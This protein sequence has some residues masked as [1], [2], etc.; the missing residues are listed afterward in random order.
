MTEATSSGRVV[1][2]GAGVGGL[3]SA[4]S[5]RRVGH[6][7]PITLVGAETHLP[8]DRPP[9]TKQVL[10]GE[11]DLPSLRDEYESL[12]LTTVLGRRAT[13]LDAASR[14]VTLDDGSQ[15]DYD[16]LVLAPGVE[17]RWL[18]GTARRPG[19]HAIRTIEDALGLRE[20]LAGVDSVVVV[21]GGFVGC[22]VAASARTLGKDVTIV[23]ALPAPLAAVVGPD[24]AAEI[25]AVHERNG[26][27][28]LAGT[29]VA[30]ILGDERV[31]GLKLS[32]GRILDAQEIVLGLGVVLDLDWLSGSGV[33]VD[34]G[35]VCSAAGR[36]SMPGV[37]AVGDAARWWHPLAGA[38][39]RVEHWTSASE[40]AEVVAANIVAGPDG[41]AT[42]LDEVPYFWSD[43]YAVKIQALGFLD[44]N[45]RT[46]VLRPND[47]F[48]VLYSHGGV[49]TGVLGL[50]AAR[51][52]MRM[53]PFIAG[54][55]SIEDAIA[56]LAG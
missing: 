9:L 10:R 53:R 18:R 54:R 37:Y 4:E 22:E 44:P 5:L 8:Y 48:V 41:A 2:V 24:A 43:Q 1:I 45:A 6:T 12:N 50:S 42:E 28:I 14:R 56:E 20:A 33:E 49:I 17:P 26:V 25:V 19:L 46:D 51:S 11:R 7:G 40:Q 32:D 34:D 47:R 23:E 16:S 21:G 13:G 36:T 39:R 27:A 31:S 29:G 3:R 35:I 30:E 15:L 38:H 52:V 55:R